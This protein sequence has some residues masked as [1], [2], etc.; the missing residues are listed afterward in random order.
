[1][2][3]LTQNTLGLLELANRSGNAGAIAIAEVLD[4]V[5]ELQDAV[6]LPANGMTT[7]TVTRRASVP[8]GSWRRI[9]DG[10][11]SEASHTI[12]VKESIGIL[13]SFSKVDEELARLSGDV[14]GFRAQEDA[15]FVE[16][17]G[18]TLASTFF[19]GNTDTTPES[20]KGL[21]PRIVLKTAANAV[22]SSGSGDDTASIWIVQWGVG[23]VYFVYPQG[24]A[25]GLQAEDLGLKLL[26]GQTTST[27]MQCYVT[28]FI[29]RHGLVVADDRCIQK[30]TN[31]ET[32]GTSNIFDDDD[33]LTALNRLPFN[34]VGGV[35]YAN[36]TIKT[37]MDIKAKD[38]TNIFYTS[39]E[40]GG[41]PVTLFRGF[42]VRRMDVLL[43]TETALS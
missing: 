41:R 10:V 40:F 14:N 11:L 37:Q 3:T 1:M 24:T 19:Y 30:V 15:A 34:G 31:I 26:S 7:H 38:Q 42:P 36:N 22:D 32:A 33:L 13:E 12:P 27:L 39:A 43:N 25:V 6:Y 16:G 18:Q 8:T 29:A 21:A 2:A 28:H 35:I 4:K 5:I 23:R 20:F 9:N 17:L